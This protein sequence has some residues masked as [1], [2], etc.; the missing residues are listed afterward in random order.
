MKVIIKMIMNKEFIS[1]MQDFQDHFTEFFGV[2]ALIFDDNGNAITKTSGF[3]DFCELIRATPEGSK[4]C[5]ESKKG[6]FD[7]VKDGEPVNYK[8]AIFDEIA[9]SIVP[10]IYKDEVI[11]AWGVGQKLVST[12]PE[13]KLNRIADE[14]GIDKEAFLTAYD[15]LPVTSIDEFRKAVYFMYET[16]T[17]I[18]RTWEQTDKI[19][20]IT[21]ITAHNIKEDLSIIIGY[22]DLIKLRYSDVMDGDLSD[23]LKLIDEHSKNLKQTAM[24]L[25]AICEREV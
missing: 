17:T 5:R 20:D 9:D 15:K 25:I 23:Y 2:A 21:S 12:I 22:A 19:R 6:L 14:F 3:T 24:R 18:M 4:R 11:A 13:E 10:V 1:S 7:L 8:C 16:V